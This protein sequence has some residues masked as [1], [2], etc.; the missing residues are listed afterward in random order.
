MTAVL[1]AVPVAVQARILHDIA[2]AKWPKLAL[3]T[4]ASH[5]N[6]T[7][8]EVQTIANR[9]GYPDTASMATAARKLE[10]QLAARQVELRA[11]AQEH[12]DAG[13]TPDQPTEVHEEAVT[14][15]LLDIP[16]EDLTPDP[17]NP[18]ETLDGIEDLAESIRSVGLLQP[19]VARRHKGKVYLV[20]GHRRLAAVR[21]LGWNEVKVIVRSHMRPDD[22]LAAMLIENGQRSDLDPIEEARG[23]R[24]LQA[25]LDCSETE[26][27]TKIGRSLGYVNGRLLLLNLTAE[28]QAAVRAGDL[29]VTAGTKKARLNSGRV[30]PGAVGRPAVGHLSSTHDLATRVRNRCTRLGHSKG[31]G[32]GV[33]GVACGLCWE[34]VIRADERE[35]IHLVSAQLGKCVTCDTPMDATA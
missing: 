28:E 9:F 27:G 19:V 24:K 22:V 14:E 25:K 13:E 10:A 23:L 34:S 12:A 32:V 35:H 29:G 31:H 17:D 30:R 21:L 7:L 1:E 3:P 2:A 8:D 11:L 16:I 26:L 4:I 6:L 5:F 20:A 33:G 15:Q 18:R